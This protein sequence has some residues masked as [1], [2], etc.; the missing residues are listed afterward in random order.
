MLYIIE[1][2]FYGEEM[3]SKFSGADIEEID[4]LFFAPVFA[5]DEIRSIIL[6]G[7]KKDIPLPD[8]EMIEKIKDIKKIIINIIE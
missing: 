3:R 7:M 4:R 5:H 6:I 1:N 2:P 8:T